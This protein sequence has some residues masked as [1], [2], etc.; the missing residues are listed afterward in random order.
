MEII[1]DLKPSDK[2]IAFLE[3]KLFNYNCSKVE[4]Y[5]YENFIIKAISN[6][7]SIIAGIHVDNSGQQ[8]HIL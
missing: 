2:D 1:F 6:S 8:G 5:S 3:Q 7:D 4:D